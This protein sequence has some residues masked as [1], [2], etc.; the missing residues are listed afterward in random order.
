MMM[1]SRVFKY[2]KQHDPL[3]LLKGQASFFSSFGLLQL[4][5]SD[6]LIN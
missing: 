6:F 3:N 4:T 1:N 5:L 2:S